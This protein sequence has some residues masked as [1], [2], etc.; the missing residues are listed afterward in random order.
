MDQGHN[1]NHGD[2]KEDQQDPP[3]DNA[4]QNQSATSL[5]TTHS[6]EVHKT[7]AL[8]VRNCFLFC[9]LLRITCTLS[10][11]PKI[12]EQSQV[13]GI[14]NCAFPENIHTKYPYQYHTQRS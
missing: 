1:S 5:K 12:D 6:R 8:I 2:D 7:D 10:C 4:D 9:S 14:K 13:A 3:A 11:T